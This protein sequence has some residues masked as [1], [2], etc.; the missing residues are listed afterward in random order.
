MNIALG[1]PGTHAF[2]SYGSST[3][4]N[5]FNQCYLECKKVKMGHLLSLGQETR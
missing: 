2:S 1:V 5:E 4:P 3:E